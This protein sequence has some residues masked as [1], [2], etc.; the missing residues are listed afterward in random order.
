MVPWPHP[1]M[2]HPATPK[3]GMQ[4]LVSPANEDLVELLSDS[5]AQEFADFDP[6]VEPQN[7]WDPPASMAAFLQRHFN[8]CLDDDEKEKIMTDFPK[9]NCPALQA[10]ELDD[11]SSSAAVFLAGS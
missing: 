11:L 8:R 5:E 2:I 3:E 6:S 7:T 10:P 9:P 1:A 4:Q